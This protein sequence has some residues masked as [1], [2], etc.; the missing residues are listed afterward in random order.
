MWDVTVTLL[1]LFNWLLLDNLKKKKKENLKINCVYHKVTK[2]NKNTKQQNIA[3]QQY[4]ITVLTVETSFLHFN[5]FVNTCCFRL[6]YD[7]GLL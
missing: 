5:Y 4:R 7:V 6:T 2:H 3:N 1:P